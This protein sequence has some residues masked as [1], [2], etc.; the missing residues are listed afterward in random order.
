M[1]FFSASSQPLA[2]SYLITEQQ[3]CRTCYLQLMDQ[4]GKCYSCVGYPYSQCVKLLARC[5][6]GLYTIYILTT[7]RLHATFGTRAV[8]SKLRASLSLLRSAILISNVEIYAHARA[9]RCKHVFSLY[10][11]DT[12]MCVNIKN[13]KNYETTP[14]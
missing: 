1:H 11:F 7:S 10:V 4:Y 12:F 14:D 9:A 5:S 6:V 2:L 13:S 3:A 8:L